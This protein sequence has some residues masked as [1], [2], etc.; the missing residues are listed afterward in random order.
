MAQS[1]SGDDLPS[2][3]DD[4][5][6]DSQSNPPPDPPKPT[7]SSCASTRGLPAPSTCESVTDEGAR[8][9]LLS[10]ND[11]AKPLRSDEVLEQS[12][13][14]H[15][16]QTSNG[17]KPSTP[18]EKFRGRGALHAPA[19]AAP[20][21]SN[22]VRMVPTLKCTT[23]KSTGAHI[24]DPSLVL[25]ARSGAFSARHVSP[26]RSARQDVA[27]ELYVM[28]S[29]SG[30]SSTSVTIST[31]T[32]L[33]M[34][35]PWV[36]AA[37]IHERCGL[38]T[39]AGSLRGINTKLH[40]VRDIS[41]AECG[42]AGDDDEAKALITEL[43]RANPTKKYTTELAW[44]GEAAVAL[45]NAWYPSK[46]RTLED[47]VAQRFDKLQGGKRSLRED[48]QQLLIH[49]Q[50]SLSALSRACE[51]IDSTHPPGSFVVCD[52][53]NLP[54]LVLEHLA[55]SDAALEDF[56]C[57]TA[58]A[59]PL[60]LLQRALSRNTSLCLVLPLPDTMMGRLPTIRRLFPARILVAVTY[61]SSHGP[62]PKLSLH[63]LA[64][65]T[66]IGDGA[67]RR[68]LTV[69][70]GTSPD[71]L[72]SMAFC[73]RH[74]IRL[75]LI[76]GSSRLCE[77]LRDAWPSRA[78]CKFDPHAMQSRLSCALA[79]HADVDTLDDL[80]VIL[81]R[82]EVI[83]HAL[84]SSAPSLERLCIQQLTGDRLLL[85]AQRAR[86]K[87][88]ASSRAYVWPHALLS[89]LSILLG[90]AA[91]IIAVFTADAV[92]ENRFLPDL[93]FNDENRLPQVLDTPGRLQYLVYTCA[94]LP[95]LLAVIDSIHGYMGAGE[96][97][98]AVER[99]A[100]LVMQALYLYRCRAGDYADA[101]L[102][103]SAPSDGGTDLST[104]RQALLKHDLAS[105]GSVVDECGAL[106]TAGNNRPAFGAF[107][108][109]PSIMQWPIAFATSVTHGKQSSYTPVSAAEIAIQSER[110]ELLA[111]P[112]VI[113]G[114][115]YLI[116]RV[117]PE[118]DRSLGSARHFLL[119]VLLTR[120]VA[121][122]AAAVGSAVA[123]LG[124]TRW[125]AITIAVAT[126]ASRVL[127][128][129]RAEARRR[130]LMRAAATLNA[131]KVRWES[132]PA[133]ERAQQVEVD[134]LVLSVEQAVEATLP[135]A[136]S[137]VAA[138]RAGQRA[139]DALV[140]PARSLHA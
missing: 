26:L 2:G 88:L 37:R 101:V 57:S 47:A 17:S 131:A 12:A 24:P 89:S 46:K 71:Q 110:N 54:T 28:S 67:P 137:E 113:D 78:T 87:Y 34:D 61:T 108:V 134:R 115:T 122:A 96:T 85:V 116:E 130:A 42:E 50:N 8:A 65:L 18:R 29:L 102:V 91:T 136:P 63:L 45:H 140:T 55:A 84:S 15:G 94:S 31:L 111:L 70:A 35:E 129:T 132:L 76:E 128:V 105:I 11:I 125:V 77:L 48:K 118:L 69:F 6:P 103:R 138:R 64:A 1:D 7:A 126:A 124:H 121:L 4:D 127:Q 27:P 62:P 82:G 135:P 40:V 90:V 106:V 100:G 109:A 73:A 93:H 112:D 81:S 25:S 21:V 53:F 104:M 119:V 9:P 139:A 98:S 60:V 66:Q 92:A 33:L 23:P 39:M 19:A 30:L 13:G 14:M 5:E 20:A 75:L 114:D 95:A 97:S 72:S 16:A 80:Q 56:F 59:H 3:S 38:C 133:E 68:A 36:E 58:A 83:V 123:V 22:P 86:D 52:I 99:A 74:G 117:Q 79:M 43:L 107:Q 51:S 49:V 10:S 41:G 44:D 120:S 32:A